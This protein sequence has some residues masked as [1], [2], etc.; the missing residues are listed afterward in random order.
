MESLIPKKDRDGEMFSKDAV[1]SPRANE[2]PLDSQPRSVPLGRDNHTRSVSLPDRQAGETLS[3]AS[4]RPSIR[5]EAIF[6][7]EVEK[8]KPNPYQPRKDFNDEEIEDLA[9]SVREFG[10]IQPLVVTKV[11]KETETGTSVEYELITGE[12]RLLAAKKIG[13]RSVP[14]IVKRVDVGKAKLEMA[15]VENIQRSDLN[16]LEIA[17]GYARLQD[18]FNLTQQEVASR[19]G[20]SRASVANTV[21]LL[22]LPGEMQE[23]LG[24]GKINASQAIALLAT[25]DINEQ[26]RLFSE[27]VHG[28]TIKGDASHAAK[29]ETPD[30]EKQ[31]WEKRLEERFGAPVKIMRRDGR[32]KMEIRFHSK[33]EWQAILDKLLGGE[34]PET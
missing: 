14:A 22:A 7:I 4:P 3:Q 23:A 20:K 19:V 12:R 31:Y 18:E 1:I 10:I 11:E 32:G 26:R 2:T 28:K 24:A 13:L 15:L 6:Q 5:D 33:E 8:I 25:S 21:R 17:R 30:P 27:F 34:N 16:P 9:R 29:A